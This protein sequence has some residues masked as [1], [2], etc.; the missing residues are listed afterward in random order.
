MQQTL[1]GCAFCDAL[2][3]SER[4]IAITWGKDEQVSHPICV[5]CADQEH[6]NLGERDHHACDSCGLVVD[7]LTALTRF[8]VE[9]GHLEGPLQLCVRCSPTGPVTYWTRDLETHVVDE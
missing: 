8:R 1:S 9:L 4:G 5:D 7:T 3:G 6:P 2:P